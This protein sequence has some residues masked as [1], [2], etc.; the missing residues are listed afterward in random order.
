[1][2][3]FI[4]RHLSEIDGGGVRGYYSLL[5]LKLLMTMVKI[6]E[7]SFTDGNGVERPAN[8][9]FWPHNQP[10]HVSHT[11]LSGDSDQASRNHYLPCH[12]FDTISGTS[13]GGYT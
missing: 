2:H 7:Q 11:A 5:I 12:Y 9:S 4:S 1:M 8:S 6:I 13:T 3:I 10:L